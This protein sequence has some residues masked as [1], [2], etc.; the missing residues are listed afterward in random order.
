M[1]HLASLINMVM[2]FSNTQTTAISC[3]VWNTFKQLGYES[4]ACI[5]WAY[6]YYNH[7]S[8]MAPIN[9]KSS[10]IPEFASTERIKQTTIQTK[11]VY[12]YTRVQ[13]Y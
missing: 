3:V 4:K 1:L 10:K 5:T 8:A 12:S 7:P 2:N 11:K 6:F 13:L 9:Y